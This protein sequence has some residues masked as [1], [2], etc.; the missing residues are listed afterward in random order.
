[1][2][3]LNGT[4][5]SKAS[6]QGMTRPQAPNALRSWHENLFLGKP[7]PQC[8]H[9][10]EPYPGAW[11]Q[12]GAEIYQQLKATTGILVKIG[13]VYLNLS[14]ARCGKCWNQKNTSQNLA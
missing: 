5:S 11:C 7:H 9:W 4:I 10:G 6:P 3:Y 8:Y 12:I 1:M 14:A 2:A 13:Q